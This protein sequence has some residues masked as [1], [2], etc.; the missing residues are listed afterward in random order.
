[1]LLVNRDS[2]S[3]F[4]AECTEV[5]SSGLPESF[6]GLDLAGDEA[7][8]P[9]DSGFVGL[10]ERGVRKGLGVTVHAG[11]FVDDERGIWRAIDELGAMRIGHGRAAGSSKALLDR[12]ARDAVMMELSLSSNLALGA[13]QT[14][15][16]H[17]VRLFVDSGLPICFNTDV[18]LHAGTTMRVEAELAQQALGVGQDDILDIQ[19]RA[20]DFRFVRRQ[21]APS[22]ED[23]GPTRG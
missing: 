16:D 21:S 2:P 19:R 20:Y 14:I 23:P 1:V 12:L 22:E 4:I 5:V 17:P 9:D 7:T 3:S 13:V 10:F 18:P 11:E 6:V 15:D 8:H